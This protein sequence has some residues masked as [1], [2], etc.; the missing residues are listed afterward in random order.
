VVAETLREKLIR[1]G[2]VT[3]FNADTLVKLVERHCEPERYEPTDQD[4]L[5]LLRDHPLK[6]DIVMAAKEMAEYHNDAGQGARQVVMFHDALDYAR[7][8]LKAYG[9]DAS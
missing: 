4:L 7:K 9:H 8:V 6:A 5:E 1:C 3:N 2:W